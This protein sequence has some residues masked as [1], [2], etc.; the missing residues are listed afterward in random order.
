M[1]VLAPKQTFA[2]LKRRCAVT[3]VYCTIKP[4]KTHR[5]YCRM[6]LGNA[7]GHSRLTLDELATTVVNAS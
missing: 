1:A 3:I 2:G 7:N 5:S 4:S 6:V